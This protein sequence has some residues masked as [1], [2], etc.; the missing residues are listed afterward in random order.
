MRQVGSSVQALNAEVAALL[1]TQ[2]E[3]L[4]YLPELL[5]DLEARGSWPEVI[6]ELLRS[7]ELPA[8][9]RV[10]DLGCGKG[11]VALAVAAAFPVKVTG[12]DAFAP[13]LEEARR[14]AEARGLAG[15]CR[16]LLADFRSWKVGR[17]FEGLIW[18]SLGP[19]LGGIGSTASWLRGFVGPGGWLIV[20][21]CYWI[22][23]P[24]S[25]PPAYRGYGTWKA[26]CRELE[27]AGLRILR[28]ARVRSE[29]VRKAH[30]LHQASIARRARLPVER[31]PDTADLIGRYVEGQ[32]SKCRFLEKHTGSAVWL[33]QRPQ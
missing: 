7:Q 24:A 5:A 1:D 18:A 8:D 12:V 30:R 26:T 13:F 11:A 6:V 32:R 2:V 4:P 20:D 28:E 14:Q 22:S 25:V 3:V 29:K 9:A 21:D 16:F 31:H 19:L 17:P 15:R 27:K 10:L 33:F 23:K